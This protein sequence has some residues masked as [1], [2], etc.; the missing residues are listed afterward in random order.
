MQDLTLVG[1][2]LE[3]L[4]A[5]LEPQI[6]ACLRA[7]DNNLASWIDR[8]PGVNLLEDQ[9]LEVLSEQSICWTETAGIVDR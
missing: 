1:L 4:L 2:W 8:K 5:S 9:S 7:R 3:S 6:K